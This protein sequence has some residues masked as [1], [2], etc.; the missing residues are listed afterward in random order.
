[1]L[2]L[3]VEAVLD[4]EIRRVVVADQTVQGTVEVGPHGIPARELQHR[5]AQC[6]PAPI[7]ERPLALRGLVVDYCAFTSAMVL[8]NVVA[9]RVA[10][11]L[12]VP[13]PDL[14]VPDHDVGPEL[15]A[16]QNQGLPFEREEVP[17]ARPSQDYKV[18]PLVREDSSFFSTLDITVS[19]HS[20]IRRG[21][22]A[23]C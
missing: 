3:L 22:T 17:E 2:E 9:S 8:Q 12:R 20:S 4:E 16:P 7:Q 6:D 10:D 21:C 13:R 23:R 1:V 18:R 11:D 19:R 15:I 5:V 14:Y